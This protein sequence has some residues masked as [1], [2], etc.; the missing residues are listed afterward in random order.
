MSK[1]EVPAL[2]YAKDALAPQI[3]ART[4]DV[5][6]EK[7]HKGYLRKLLAIIRDKPEERM[8]LEALIRG[9]QG[10]LFNNAAQVWNH[11][12]YWRSMRPDGG[13]APPPRLRERIA[14]AFGSVDAFKREFAAAAN[15]E[16]GSGWAW[17]VKDANGRLR[18]LN[19]DD[20][21]NPLQHDFVPLLTLDVWEHAY[22]LD[23]QSERDRYVRGFLDHLMNW[24]F[25]A[26]NLERANPAAPKPAA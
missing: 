9:S 12:F 5:H 25:V 19:S 26:S 1:I 24:D 18:V 3:S 13:G 21:E 4:V 8:D 23:Y 16:F 15:G 17:L 20:A 6:Y 10:D 22:Y 14:Q 11:S 2:P 7:H